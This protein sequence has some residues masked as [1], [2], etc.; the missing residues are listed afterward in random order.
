M[1]RSEQMYMTLYGDYISNI[2]LMSTDFDKT[3]L[4]NYVLHW[5]Y[6]SHLLLVG[7]SV[8]VAGVSVADVVLT[9]GTVEVM[10][11]EIKTFNLL[12][13]NYWWW[14]LVFNYDTTSENILCS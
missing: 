10:N 11:D 4:N 14:W 5:I 12:W 1:T 8:V 9:A 2:W 7:S 3:K 13:T 6:L